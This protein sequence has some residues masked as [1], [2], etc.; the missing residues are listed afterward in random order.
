MVGYKDVWIFNTYQS[1]EEVFDIILGLLNNTPLPILVAKRPAGVIKTLNKNPLE[2]SKCV[3]KIIPIRG[4]LKL[5]WN[6]ATKRRDQNLDFCINFF[7]QV[8]QHLMGTPAPTAPE[9]APLQASTEEEKVE[10]KE[11]TPAK[12]KFCPNC[13][14]SNEGDASYC[15]QC[16]SNLEV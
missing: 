12:T 2:F 10:V 1:R 4:G 13:G 14:E 11:K 15:F 7:Q 5:V 8:K 6:V 16:G 9:T 3:L